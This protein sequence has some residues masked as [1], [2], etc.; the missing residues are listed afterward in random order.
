MQLIAHTNGV[1]MDRLFLLSLLIL[2]PS[3]ALGTDYEVPFFTPATNT[4]Q[5]GFI[6]VI[7]HS[8]QSGSV[9]VLGIDDSGQS[10]AQTASF[11]LAAGQTK[12][13]NS[14]D[15]E[16]GN[17]GKGLSGSLG[18]GSGNWRLILRTSLDIEVLAYIRTPSGFLT[19]IHDSSSRG[20][21]T[22]N[23]I[24]IFNP[25]Q[26][27]NQVSSLRI[28][29]PNTSTVTV[30]ITAAD[31]APAASRTSG[32]VTVNLGPNEAK[33]FTALDLEQ[34]NGSAGISGAFGDGQGKWTLSINSSQP[35][36]VMHLLTDPNGLLTNL[37]TTPL[38]FPGAAGIYDGLFFSPTYGFAQIVGALT[39]DG[40][41]FAYT[42]DFDEI[43]IGDYTQLG[44]TISINYSANI[45][46]SPPY[47][48]GNASANFKARDWISGTF[49]IAGTNG[50][51]SLKY[52]TTFER[53]SGLD[54]IAGSYSGSEPGVSFSATISANGAFTGGDT[55]GCSYNG[56]FSTIRPTFNL[57][58]FTG[59]F[60]CPGLGTNSWSGAAARVDGSAFG[61]NSALFVIAES[62]L[63]NLAFALIKD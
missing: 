56:N 39:P 40:K 5:Q 35:I 18:D 32:T 49:S 63:T 28:I 45:E 44:N 3:L 31:D 17:S 16:L 8:N 7:N 51:F 11:S 48:S 61:D 26:N 53:E 43:F 25:G 24:P 52:S 29:N 55:D 10:S 15:I 46:G 19:S 21:D 38:N 59:S 1:A 33:H 12:H 34:G 42:P 14:Q 4:Q 50:N 54:L 58:T 9:T 37:S 27:V 30:E 41:L 13:F 20:T 22:Y 62:P 57:Y 6:R 23:Q 60:T 47:A 2:I 36:V